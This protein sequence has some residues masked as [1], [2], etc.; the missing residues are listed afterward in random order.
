MGEPIK[1]KLKCPYRKTVY[2]I[3]KYSNI[4]VYETEDGEEEEKS[5]SSDSN[6]PAFDDFEIH[7]DI[8]QDCYQEECAVWKDGQCQM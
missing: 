8:F 7:S 5:K 4:V 3:H 6:T 2:T 1:K